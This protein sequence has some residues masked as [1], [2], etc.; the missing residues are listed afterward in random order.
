MPYLLTTPFG[1]HH[2]FDRHSGEVI[3]LEV[4]DH[5]FYMNSQEEEENGTLVP[6][7]SLS[8]LLAQGYLSAGPFKTS[9][10]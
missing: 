6:S 9:S 3:Q 1:N 5:N 10:T 4:S 8:S 2:A 7:P